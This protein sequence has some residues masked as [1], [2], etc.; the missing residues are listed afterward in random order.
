VKPVFVLDCAAEVDTVRTIG[1]T[2]WE[3][4]ENRRESLA[5]DNGGRYYSP[6]ALEIIYD[7]MADLRYRLSVG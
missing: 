4:E 7:E 3:N 5:A 2:E 6:T 1:V